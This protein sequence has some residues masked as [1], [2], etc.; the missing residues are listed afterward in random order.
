MAGI[1]ESRNYYADHL[2]AVNKSNT[3]KTTHDVLND[4]G[5]VIVSKSKV[6]TP[7]IANKIARFKLLQP[8]ENTVMLEDMISPKRLYTDLMRAH[9]A[10]EA[11]GGPRD[12][13][14]GAILK[15]Q[16]LLYANYPLLTQKLTVLSEQLPEHYQTALVTSVLALHVALEL[17]L[18]QRQQHAVFIAALMHDAGL[19]NIDP[20]IVA[21]KGKLEP[22]EWKALQG[23]AVIG[24]YF[25]DMVPDL[26]KTVGIAVMEHHERL[27]GTGYPNGKT[28]EKLGMEGQVIAITDM[29]IAVFRLRLQPLGYLFKDLTPV[30][31]MNA[32]VY[33]QEIHQAV[34]RIMQ[35]S[36]G[37]PS[38]ALENDSM[39]SLIS[40]LLVSQ[41][42]ISHSFELLESATNELGAVQQQEH[43]RRAVYMLERLQEIIHRS[44]LFSTE[45][46]EWLESV[47]KSQCTDD[48]QEVE[49]VALMFD[50]FGYQLRQLHKLL[51]IAASTMDERWIKK[52][53]ELG[54]LLDKI[55]KHRLVVVQ[56]SGSDRSRQAIKEGA[57]QVAT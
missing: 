33:P 11:M 1:P 41:K 45:L 12:S 31:Q 48:Y 39:G 23:H 13:D 14:I 53:A 42:L 51:S 4:Q 54:E 47:N 27:D 46:R 19:L 17:G 5:L 44:G 8:L 26:P 15:K 38:R 10:H 16:C 24:K 29:I 34:M 21:K 35:R 20:V 43:R 28:A 52:C 25:L 57:Q 32:P 49:Y 37:S 3:V 2:A 50:E 55:P 9:E 40:L 6:I 7:E 18:S 56:D 22:S 36:T 30:L